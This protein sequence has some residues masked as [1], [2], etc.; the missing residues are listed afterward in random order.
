M[1]NTFRR[2]EDHVVELLGEV[3]D[4][5]AGEGALTRVTADQIQNRLREKLRKYR[6]GRTKADSSMVT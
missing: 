5:M 2:A 6:E 1:A 3:L 4:E